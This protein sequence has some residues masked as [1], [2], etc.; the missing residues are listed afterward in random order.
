MKKNKIYI[1]AEI[2]L[3]HNGNINLAKRMISAAK[4]AGAD[5]VKFQSFKTEEFMSNTKI[6]Y[7]YGKNKTKE[8]MFKMFKR[9][10]FKNYW[11][12]LL[13]N[14][15]KKKKID[16]LTSVADID[17]LKRYLSINPKIIKLA[18]ED[19]INFKLLKAVSKTNKYII[20]STGMADDDEIKSALKHF[21]NKKKLVLLHCVSLY[22]T[23]N[24]LTNLMRINSLKEK[25][26]VKVGYS[27]HTI[28]INACI[29]ASALGAKVI[30]KH[31]TL[32]RN[33]SGPDQRLSIEPRELKEMVKQI[34]LFEVMMGNGKIPPSSKEFN[35]RKKFRRSIVAN[36]LIKKDS[37]ITEK[38]LDLKRP[39]TGL[40]PKHFNK[41]L[42]KR[43]KKNYINNQKIFL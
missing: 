41:L 3:N 12:K 15:C 14:F 23:E 16:F 27:D 5:A 7:T 13:K 34:R 42:G 32:N 6:I 29:F 24:K 1:I 26:K 36:T 35:I 28:G 38:M 39:G 40:H 20:L 21:K 30:E 9:L 19:L 43:A 22:P 4:L 33:L 11:Y 31:F 25:Y 8:N 2:G 17:N 18:S 37:I 10:E